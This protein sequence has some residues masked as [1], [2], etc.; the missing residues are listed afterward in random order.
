MS[1]YLKKFVTG[2][3]V[4]FSTSKRNQEAF[5]RS[6]LKWQDIA[7]TLDI[8]D[9]SVVMFCGAKSNG[10]SGCIRYLVNK[11]LQDNP[12]DIQDIDDSSEDGKSSSETANSKHIY[13][14]DLDPGQP[15]M[16]TPG[17]VSVHL[18]HSPLESPTYMN[19]GRHDQV[20]MSSV[21]GTNMSVNPKMYIENCRYIIE[22]LKDHRDEHHSNAPIFINTMGHIRNVGL[23]MLMDLIKISRPTDLVVLNVSGDPMRVIY[24][25]LSAEA[26]T[27]TRASFYYETH[28]EYSSKPLDYKYH[29]HNLEF[30]FAD[31][32]PIAT[33]NRIALQL[34]YLSKI[35]GS[36]FKPVMQIAPKSLSLSK[37]SFY[38]VSSYPL[39]I[40]IVLELIRHSWIHLV[41][42]VKPIKPVLNADSICSIID[43]VGENKMLG[44]GIV[45]EI[46]LE[47][48][49]LL[50]VTPLSDEQLQNQINCVIKPLSIQVP[51]EVIYAQ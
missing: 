19:V 9:G 48:R 45:T 18:I 12:N 7:A 33:K 1:K 16:S 23:A 15:E 17:V 38:C 8:R 51:R 27:N 24:A 35:P 26:M 47:T 30:C 4:T 49:T 20:V 31:S 36:M 29:V 22:R 10:K 11:C 13:Y 42:L 40:G 44:C 37:I 3:G 21:G 32:S 14:V 25:D 34:A 6:I 50:V 46:D 5:E 2:H 43:D 28:Q 39:K 41:H